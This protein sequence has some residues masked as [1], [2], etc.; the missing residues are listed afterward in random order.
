MRRFVLFVAVALALASWNGPAKAQYGFGFGQG[1]DPNAE[2]EAA[3]S[4]AKQQL[5]KYSKPSGPGALGSAGRPAIGGGFRDRYGR[6]DLAGH[7][8]AGYPMVRGELDTIHV[9]K[10]RANGGRR[11]FTPPRT[12]NRRR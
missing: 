7:A 10:G 6:A 2:I 9:S 5:Q 12:A 3:R 8:V 1:S 4:R 11:S